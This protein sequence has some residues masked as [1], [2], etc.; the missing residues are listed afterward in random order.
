METED[1]N[2]ISDIEL[3][4][5]V[6]DLDREKPPQRDLWEGIQ[7]GILDHPQARRDRDSNYWMPYAVAAS[8]LIAVSA[9]MLNLVQ[10]QGGYPQEVVGI[11]RLEQEYVRVRNP[12]MEE[13][14]TVNESLDK[15]TKDD[16]FR[17]L[18]IL[19]QARTDLE[20]QVRENPDN[21]R[22]VEMLMT[23]HEQ[24]LELLK[25]DYTRPSRSM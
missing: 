6:R 10:M 23:I 1:K 19:A 17:N 22:L 7:R 15:K 11:D 12:M 2:L 13:F 4:R 5:L 16:L 20:R 18:D 25:Q 24:E 14:F 9:L 21:R 3:A 8:M